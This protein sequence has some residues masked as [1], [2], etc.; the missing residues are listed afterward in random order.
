MFSKQI[1]SHI[2]NDGILNLQIPLGIR[3]QDVEIMLVIQPKATDQPEH[4][5]L[6]AFKGKLKNSANFNE[7]PVAIQKR[8]RDE[9]A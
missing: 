4:L 7:D 5:T 3:D 6:D 8:M 9:W 1:A 2:G